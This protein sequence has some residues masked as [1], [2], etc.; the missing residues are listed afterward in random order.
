VVLVFDDLAVP[1]E[2]AGPLI[3]RLDAGALA[4]VGDDGLLA[5]GLPRLGAAGGAGLDV[6][7]VDD[8]E[9][10]LVDVDRVGVLGE[11]V[12]FPDLDRA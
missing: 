3:G 1:D 11:V 2:Q 12:Y 9:G 8:V 10:D 4:G 6:L 5:A 7:A